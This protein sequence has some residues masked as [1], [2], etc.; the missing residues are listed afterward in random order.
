MRVG[1]P[2]RAAFYSAVAWPTSGCRQF[3]N[4]SMLLRKMMNVGFPP[5]R[6]AD[7]LAP[8][9]VHSLDATGFGLEP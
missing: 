7:A 1:V 5:A 4:S 9:A 2:W 3:D 8:T 6:P